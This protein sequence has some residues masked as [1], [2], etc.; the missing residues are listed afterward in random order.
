MG[1]N[2]SSGAQPMC[3]FSLDVQFFYGILHASIRVCVDARRVACMCVAWR[4]YLLLPPFKKSRNT[5]PQFKVT[6]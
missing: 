3:D 6:R 4:R 1:K 2:T 5:L